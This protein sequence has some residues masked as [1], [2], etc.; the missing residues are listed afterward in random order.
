MDRLLER[1][2]V[3]VAGPLAVALV[4]APGLVGDWPMEWSLEHLHHSGHVAFP[5]AAFVIFSGFV[6]REIRQRGWPTFSW[7]L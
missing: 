6:A 2:A 5:V 1:I 4:V 3:G 7:R